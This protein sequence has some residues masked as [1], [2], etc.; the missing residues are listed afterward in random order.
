MSS[1]GD[2]KER[3]IDSLS[4]VALFALHAWVAMV[5]GSLL[6][7]IAEVIAEP[8]LRDAPRLESVV[9]RGGYLN[10]IAWIPGIVFGFFV[11]RLLKPRRVACWVWIVGVIWL[12]SAIWYLA[13]HYD[14][15]YTQGCS[16]VRTVVNDF[17]ILDAQRCG[18]GQSTLAGLFFTMPAI[19]SIGYAVGARLA[20]RFRE[21][22]SEAE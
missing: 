6:M 20:L 3:L 22:R 17:F 16:I 19:N 12:T 10:P 2:S 14:A 18:G 15:S 11:N 8:F 7:V 21:K 1:A 13:R 9:D 5:I 4:A